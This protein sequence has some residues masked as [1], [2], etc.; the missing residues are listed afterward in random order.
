M[1]SSKLIPGEWVDLMRQSS[2]KRE[3]LDRDQRPKGRSEK[4]NSIPFDRCDL[5]FYFIHKF[6]AAPE[7]TEFECQKDIN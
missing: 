1:R 6:R 4:K 3:D 5:D 2:R 7:V